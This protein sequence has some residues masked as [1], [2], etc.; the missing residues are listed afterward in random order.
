M[1]NT[2]ARTP[3]P[4]RVVLYLRIRGDLHDQVLRTARTDRRKINETA[5]ILLEEALA[6]R[7]LKGQAMPDPD[8]WAFD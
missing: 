3:A 8:D 2:Q 7:A 5:E 1:P 6:A 4:E